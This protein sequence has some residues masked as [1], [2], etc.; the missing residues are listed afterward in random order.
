MIAGMDDGLGRI[1][2]KLKAMGAEQNTLIV[3][4]GDNGAPLKQGAWNGS[5]NLPLTGEKGMLT[6]GGIRT[7]FVAAWPGRIPAGQVYEHPVSSLDVAATAVALAGRSHDATLD[8]VNLIPFVTGEN[9]SAPHDALFWGWRS[10][11]AVLKFPW[12]LIHLGEKERYLFD[13]TK[14]EGETKNLLATH[15]DI[16]ARLDAKLANWSTTLQPPGLPESSN[17]QDNQFFAAHVNKTI[18]QAT[19]RRATM[20]PAGAN[21]SIQ[22]WLCRNGT[23][24]VKGGALHITPDAKATAKFRPFLTSSDIALVGP[25]TATLKVRAKSGGAST[26]TW[27]TKTAS[28]T[29]EQ[30]AP[31]DWPAS[32]DWQEVKVELPE[33]NRLIHLRIT[34]PSSGTGLE[35]QSIELR[36]PKGEPRVWRFTETK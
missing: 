33:T 18:D 32:A 23:L 31:F 35:F 10:Q 4:I 29:P 7:P 6:D 19:K 9:K 16:A 5:V 26:V 30:T 1:R 28:F 27:R 12:K 15:P 34:P 21:G 8:G 3:F 11:A 17:D 2:A 20:P 36:A 22:G 24:A 14:P 13:V 25:V